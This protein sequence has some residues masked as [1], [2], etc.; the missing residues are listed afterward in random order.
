MIADPL[1]KVKRVTFHA[2]DLPPGLD[3]T[4]ILKQ[5]RYWLINR[6]LCFTG[7][8][9]FTV[10][11]DEVPDF[12]FTFAPINATADHIVLG[13]HFFESYFR[14]KNLTNGGTHLTAILSDD[15][16]QRDFDQWQPIRRSGGRGCDRST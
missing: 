12:F 3:D 5:L 9:R 15:V 11:H 1:F 8:V 2:A 16:D 14:I 13:V 4:F 10:Q 6:L 7:Y